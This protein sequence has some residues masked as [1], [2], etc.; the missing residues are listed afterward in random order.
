LAWINGEEDLYEERSYDNQ[1][2]LTQVDRKNTTSGGNLVSRLQHLYDKRGR[3]YRRIR[4]E[5]T[6]SSGAIG[7]TLTDNTWYDCCGNVLKEQ[8]GGTKA[9]RKFVY[10]GA[11][12]R[13]K[14]Y[15]AYD[16]DESG[17][18]A[19]DD[20]TGD[21]V[22]EQ[23]E[24][25][26][27]AAG[28]LIS[29]TTFHRYHSASAT[30]ALSA[31][32]TARPE[33][34][35]Y[36][37]D[38]LGRLIATAVYGNGGNDST[39][40]TRPSVAPAAS[41]TVLVSKVEYNKDGEA[42][43]MFDAAGKQTRMEFDDAGRRKNVIK[44]YVDGNPATGGTDADVTVAFTYTADGLL[45]TLTAKQPSS[46]DDQV[47]TYIYGTHL[48]GITPT[49]YR[50]DLVRAVI[51]PDSD[52]V[53]SP[54][55]NGTDGVYD[56]V[57]YKY[58]RQGQV[59]EMKDQNGT[60]HA[61]D[62]DKLGRQ[63][64]DRVTTLGTG[65]DGSVRRIEKAYEV[66]GMLARVSSR[67]SATVGSGSVLNEVVLEYNALGLLDREYQSASGAKG[68][69]TPYVEYDYDETASGGELTKGY[70]L[71]SIRYPNGRLVHYQYG[72]GDN[73]SLNRLDAIADYASSSSS[74]SGGSATVF[75]SYKYLG[76]SRMVEIDYQEADVRLDLIGTGTSYTGLDRFGRVID[77]KWYDYGSSAD[78]DR[79]K[80]GYDRVSNR[81]YRENTVTSNKDEFYA[82]DG[83]H[84]LKNFDRGNLNGTYT[85][86]TGTVVK[87]Q[88]WTLDPLGN[89]TSLIDKNSGSTSLSHFRSHT[90]ANEVTTF[91]TISGTDWEDVATDRAGN[92]TTVPKPSA[93]ADGYLCK[94]KCQHRRILPFFSQANRILRASETFRPCMLT[95]A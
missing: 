36:W 17:Y 82:Y 23:R 62:Y 29:A 10:D 21:T 79:Y 45:K 59:I 94:R 60:V 66:R 56:R 19:V 14:E 67:S 57:E 31:G 33:R 68:G 75:A 12:R 18:S 1:D 83:I 88:D 91:N 58:N 35:A 38:A 69:G 39:A 4:Y 46:S 48:G 87:E 73:E 77:Q 7:D 40:F 41:D 32:S 72:S 13:T 61:Y 54:L 44:N 84:R 20:V 93:L 74:S 42:E 15:L 85:G 16:T 95:A 47:T 76:R 81:T 43:K 92:L 89:W 34:E 8:P 70:R 78:V 37:H 25:S 71:K 2:R 55:G 86:M 53:A 65:I 5:V 24:R 52:D 64:Q 3:Q 30:G 28:N 11:A 27:D 80:Y 63:T 6:P 50:N 49:V 26:Y 9:F 90:K 51:Y 22:I